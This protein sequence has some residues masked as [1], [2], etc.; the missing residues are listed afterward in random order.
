MGGRNCKRMVQYNSCCSSIEHHFRHHACHGRLLERCVLHMGKCI[1]KRQ[2]CMGIQQQR[3]CMGNHRW[4]HMGI[5]LQHGVVNYIGIRFRFSFTLGDNMSNW[6]D[7]WVYTSKSVCVVW[8][9]VLDLSF[10]VFNSLSDFMLLF[11]N[12]DGVSLFW[13]TLLGH[14]FGVIW[15]NI[16]DNRY[17]WGYLFVDNGLYNFGNNR[18]LVVYNRLD[19]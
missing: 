14:S 5:L 13:N 18:Y 7:V 3:C 11:G 17:N 1:Q 19:N 10:G 8:C 9:N 16:L 12:I 6:V 15:V 2:W 4:F